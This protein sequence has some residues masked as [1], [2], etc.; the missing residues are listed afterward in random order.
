[1]GFLFSCQPEGRIYEKHKELSPNVEWKKSDKIVFD[2]NIEDAN[3]VYNQ[4]IAFRYAYGFPYDLLKVKVTRKSPSGDVAEAVYDLLVRDEKGEYIGEAGYDIWD[5]EHLVE[6]S[7]KFPEKGNYEFT[8][9]PQMPDD[10]VPYAME[11][12]LVLDKVG[13]NH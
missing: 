5:S 13:P 10:P 3:T 12:G 2:V 11:I 6:T 1:M 9:E 4:S 7:I 8:I